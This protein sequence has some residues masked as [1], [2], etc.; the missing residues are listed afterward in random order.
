MGVV[1]TIT[2]DTAACGGL[3]LLLITIMA[4]NSPATQEKVMAV[5]Y[6]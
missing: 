1:L 2:I 4:T 5:D 3:L 6:C